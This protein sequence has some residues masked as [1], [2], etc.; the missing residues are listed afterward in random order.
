MTDD[1]KSVMKKRVL[2]VA[3]QLAEHCDSVH[4]FVTV[5]SGGEENTISYECGLG[6]FYA[7][8]GQINEWV[9]IQ[10]QFQRNEAIKRD[11]E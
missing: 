8:L 10:E 4:V 11:Q 7:R 5:H 1:E 2:D 6:N 3:T 9:V